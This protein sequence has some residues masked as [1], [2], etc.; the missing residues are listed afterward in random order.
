MFTL[1]EALEAIKDKPEFAFKAKDGYSVIDY[2]LTMKGTFIGSTERQA[3]ILKNLRGTCFDSSGKISRLMWHKFHNLGENEE[4]QSSNFDL[5]DP[6]FIEEKLD[7][8]CV[9]PISI[10]DTTEGLNWVFGTR[11]GVTDVSKMVDDWFDE[12]SESDFNRYCDYKD[13][14]QDCIADRLTPIFEFCSRQNKVVIDYPVADLVLTGIRCMDTGEYQLAINPRNSIS[15]V[16]Q[17]KFGNT[18]EEVAASVKALIG[19]EGIVVKFTDGRIVKCKSDLYVSQHRALDSVLH[20]KNI[21]KLIIEGKLDDV[22][23]LVTPDIRIKLEAYQRQVI[24]GITETETK[25]VDR[26]KDIDCDDR[27]VFAERAKGNIIT[28]FLFSLKS[29]RGTGLTNFVLK[30]CGSRIDV[31]SIRWIIGK[32]Y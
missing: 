25:I 20:E 15:I 27:K 6:H 28:P 21:L 9:A 12:L 17:R 2:N 32:E 24:N 4:Y 19:E 22:L 31:E 23:P 13:F 29:G 30:N 5:F 8:S 16:K 26:F 3:M 11:A 18:I 1:Q 14:I 10:Q 7:G